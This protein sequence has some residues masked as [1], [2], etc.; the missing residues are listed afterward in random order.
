MKKSIAILGTRGIPARYGGFETFADELS[1]RLVKK[2]K[3][4]SVYCEKCG[5]ESGVFEYEGVKLE[6]IRTFPLGPFRTILFDL[7]CLWHA[8]NRFD[9]IY[10]LGYGAALF[11]FI[12]RLWGKQVWINVDGIEWRRT[13]WNDLAKVYFKIMEFFSTITPDRIIAD[14]E[15]IKNYF[16][17]K[18]KRLPPCTF[19]PYGAPLITESQS[20]DYLKSLGLCR[21]GYYLV[22]AR[23]EPENHVRE[24]IEG[25]SRYHSKRP[26]L[27]VGGLT[28]NNDYVAELKELESE[29]VRFLGGIYN[30]EKLQ[31]LRINSFAYFHGHSVGGTNPSLLEALGC[32]NLIVAHDNVFNR[33]VAGDV[34]YYFETTEDIRRILEELEETS[35]DNISALSKQALLRIVDKY[36]WDLVVKSYLDLLK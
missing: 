36:N 27:I 3:E 28:P 32:G 23:L 10:L 16:V 8:R 2:G 30:V 31:S 25:Y 22:V 26:L 18:Y 12:P 4:V 20:N 14:A 35:A 17:G 19:I 5:S 13:K 34:G 15:G 29:R 6:Y 33:E 7:I 11:A 21:G 24:I 9:V 1:R